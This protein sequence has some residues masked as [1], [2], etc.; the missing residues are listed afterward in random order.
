M[1]DQ[2]A[3]CGLKTCESNDARREP[4]QRKSADR[5][6][7]EEPHAREPALLHRSRNATKTLLKRMQLTAGSCVPSAGI[8]SH[9]SFDLGQRCR[10]QWRAPAEISKHVCEMRD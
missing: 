2:D 6:W 3:L 8:A 4:K 10:T 5:K 1:R 7:L 9:R